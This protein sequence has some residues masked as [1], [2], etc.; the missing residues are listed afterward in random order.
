MQIFLNDL[1]TGDLSLDEAEYKG[2]IAECLLVFERTSIDESRW[3]SDK[4]EARCV[5]TDRKSPDTG[6][7]DLPALSLLSS[8]F[9]GLGRVRDDKKGKKKKKKSRRSGP[10]IFEDAEQ[11][12]ER[13]KEK[14]EEKEDNVEDVRQGVRERRKGGE[15]KTEQSLSRD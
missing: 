9:G 14:K 2:L 3:L 11:S 12:K 8:A 7:A 5:E 15:E 13:D 1:F 10:E 4:C 6:A